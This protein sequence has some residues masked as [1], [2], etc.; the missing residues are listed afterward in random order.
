MSSVTLRPF[1][2]LLLTPRSSSAFE[3]SGPPPCT[4][5]GLRPIN[6]KSVIS[7]ITEFF[8]SSLI[9]AL[10]PYFTT[11][12]LPANFCI[13][14]SASISIPA[15]FISSC[16]VSPSIINKILH[17]QDLF[18]H[19]SQTI[20]SYSERLVLPRLLQY[21]QALIQLLPFADARHSKRLYQ[22]S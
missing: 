16:I 17:C 5:I 8:K 20:N 3:I 14:G 19:L 9:I 2:N 11:T 12:V 6:F 18:F 4:T 10:P 21:C 13:Y 15:F 22:Q 1:I 7:S